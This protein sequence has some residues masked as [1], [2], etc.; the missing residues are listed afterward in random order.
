M[1]QYLVTVNATR[2]CRNPGTTILDELHQRYGVTSAEESTKVAQFLTFCKTIRGQES[3]LEYL[4]RLHTIQMETAPV[5]VTNEMVF[6]HKAYAS[7]LS[8]A[9]QD[10]NNVIAY[11]KS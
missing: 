4:H 10:T 1:H 9:K 7:F 3:L 6:T 5:S 2:I 11:A 8:A